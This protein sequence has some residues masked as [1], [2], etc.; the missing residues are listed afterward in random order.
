ML[1]RAK[2]LYDNLDVERSLLLLRQVIS[3]SSPF[4]VT[5]AQRVEAYKYIGAA[6]ALT[7]MPDSATVYFRAALERDPFTDLSPQDFTPAQLGALA[8]AKRLTFGVGSRPVILTRFRPQAEPVSFVVQTTHSAVLQVELVG[9]S[10]SARAVLFTGDSEGLRDVP[11]NGLMSNG[12]LAAPGRYRLLLGARSRLSGDRDS[13]AVP[14]L[15]SHEH[16]PLEDTLPDLQS[17][18]LMPEQRPIRAARDGLLAGFGV[19]ASALLLSNVVSD[20]GL[21]GEGPVFAMTAGG[22]GVLTGIGGYLWQLNHRTIPANVRENQHRRTAR[23]AA[24]AEVERRNRAKIAET[25]L[26][27]SPLTAA[28]GS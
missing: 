3:P 9:E 15:L 8:A 24:K 21:E 6:L 7:G 2:T 12:K 19:A 28:G 10:D 16:A 26:I 23:A 18:D 27:I 13:V 17:S 5:P 4:Q 1:G 20:P 14:F 11:W 22:L 25:V